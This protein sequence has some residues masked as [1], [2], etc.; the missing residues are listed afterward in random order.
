MALWGKTDTLAS[1]PKWLTPTITI[2]GTSASVVVAAAN[3]I[4]YADHGL[5]TG[6]PVTYDCGADANNA[7]AGLT[8]DTIYYVIR[9]DQ[10]TI[11][12]ASNTLN[13]TNG[14]EIDITGVGGNATD[15]LQV[16]PSDIYFVDTTEVGVAANKAKGFTSPGWWKYSTYTDS[17]GNTRHRA[18][19]LAELSVAVGTSGDTGVDGS[20]DSVVADS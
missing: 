15:T 10:D 7:I 12:L 16:T 6:D 14:T 11:Q 8:D 2:D 20:D 18:E 13:A 19:C 3:T 17:L 1:A 4:V 9:V 5:K